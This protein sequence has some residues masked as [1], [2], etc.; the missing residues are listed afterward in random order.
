VR[1]K[2][3]RRPLAEIVAGLEQAAVAAHAAGERPG[4]F[5]L[6]HWTVLGKVTKAGPETYDRVV[7]RLRLLLASGDVPAGPAVVVEGDGDAPRRLV[8]LRRLA[9][10]PRL[11]Q[12]RRLAG[13]DIRPPVLPG[14]PAVAVADTTPEVPV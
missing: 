2:G 10:G 13:A 5:F 7:E 11:E 8:A 14:L 9:A 3:N 1:S 4:R 12:L 6:R